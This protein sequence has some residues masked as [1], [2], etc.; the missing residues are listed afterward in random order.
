[1]LISPKTRKP[2]TASKLKR[3]YKTSNGEIVRLTDHQKK[4]ADIANQVSAKE[5]ITKT[6]ELYET[7]RNSARVIVYKNLHNGNVNQYLNSILPEAKTR[8]SEL[9]VLT[10]SEKINERRL[11]FDAVTQVIDRVEGRAVQQIQTTST[12]VSINID[13]T[14]AD[15]TT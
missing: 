11:G 14:G 12:S 5:L 1:M 13:L 9:M 2:R 7:D 15:T 6:Q 8:L 4:W 10:D 3:P